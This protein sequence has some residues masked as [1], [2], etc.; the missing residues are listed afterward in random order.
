MYGE[1][2]VVQHLPIHLL[3]E[4]YVNFHVHQT[5]NEV[6][7]RQNVE[8]TQLTTWFD[9]NSIYNDSLGL[10]YWQFSQ[11]YTWNA[12][13]KS[14]HPRQQAK[15]IGKIYFVL[16]SK[17]EQFFL[18]LLL[19]IFEDKKNWEHLRTQNGQVFTTFKEVYM[20][21]GL[22]EDD[23]KWRIC[24]K[25][26]IAIQPGIACYRLLVVILL[27]NEVTE[28]YLFW[29][30]FKTRLCN[31]VKHKLHHMN[32]YQADQEI[33]EDD[34]YDYSLWDLNRILQ[35]WKEVLLIFHQ[36]L[37]YSNSGLTEFPILSY[38]LSSIMQMKWQ[39]WQMSKEQ[40]SIL[41]KLLLLMLSWSLS[42]TIRVIFSL[43]MLLVVVGKH[44]CITLLLLR[45]EKE[46]RQHYIWHHLG[47]LLFCQIVKE[48][49][50]H[51]LR[52]LFLSFVV[53]LKCNSYMFPVLQQTKVVM[54][55]QNG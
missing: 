35:E 24:L 49:L 22:L 21:R 33:L 27:T 55:W 32:Y 54:T 20:A 10:T 26:V 12:K 30:Q 37:F 40:S 46:V 13:V 53:G 43:F 45:L 1:L 47:L 34:V 48:H 17:E 6:L 8:K 14:W 25:E 16:L 2:L 42:P 3:N 5:V 23:H 19:T 11:H 4:H 15:V 51:A 38:R 41:T 7:A 52:F 9:Y 18:Q 29:D 31:N 28:P 44:F 36:C 39:L 50:T